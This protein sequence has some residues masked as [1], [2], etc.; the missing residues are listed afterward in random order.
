MWLLSTPFLPFLAFLHGPLWN[1]IAVQVGPVVS[2]YGCRSVDYPSEM[3][4]LNKYFSPRLETQIVVEKHI[5]I[6]W[7][8]HRMRQLLDP[9]R[10]S[11]IPFNLSDLKL[12]RSPSNQWEYHRVASNSSKALIISYLIRCWIINDRNRTRWGHEFLW[13]TFPHAVCAS[14]LNSVS[15]WC[16]QL[17]RKVFELIIPTSICD[18]GS[19]VSQL[20][21]IRNGHP[22]L[23]HEPQNRNKRN[24]I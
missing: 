22:I 11:F 12:G 9:T 20:T 3:T 1:S 24:L 10:C 15:F 8:N 5:S 2:L 6:G 4:A 14:S 21:R 16:C 23:Q 7:P 18:I 17:K 13:K 19:S